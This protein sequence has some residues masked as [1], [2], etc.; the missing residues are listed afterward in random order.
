MSFNLFIFSC[1][2]VLAEISSINVPQGGESLLEYVL[3]YMKMIFN[4]KKEG[5]NMESEAALLVFGPSM[6]SLHP[7]ILTGP[8]A[9]L[10]DP[11]HHHTT[12]GIVD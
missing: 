3:R 8:P 7:C 6:L 4:K 9:S 11:P 10:I 12:L 1:L 2:R 5:G